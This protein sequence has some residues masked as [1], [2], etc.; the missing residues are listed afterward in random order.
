[1]LDWPRGKVRPPKLG[2]VECYPNVFGIGLSENLERVQIARR[3]GNPFT[4][5]LRS[6]LSFDEFPVTSIDVLDRLLPPSESKFAVL[7]GVGFPFPTSAK[8]YVESAGE[9]DGRLDTSSSG[10]TIK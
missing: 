2:L 7:D 9:F 1:M 4:L 3:G 10:L 8:F 6:Q 5:I